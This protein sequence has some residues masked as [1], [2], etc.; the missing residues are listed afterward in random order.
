M[1]QRELY[2]LILKGE[3]TN[4]VTADGKR[5]STKIKLYGEDGEFNPAV[6][7]YCEEQIAKLDEKNAGRKDT[8]SEKEKR[9]ANADLANA[10]YSS[11]EVG[12]TYTATQLAEKFTTAENK[13]SA[14]KVTAVLKPYITDNKIVV[15]KGYK[16]E[17]A[18]SKVNGYALPTEG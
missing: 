12:K 18:K 10:I 1:T 7:D 15:I 11:F 3:G 9:A 13:V 4:T 6:I 14:Q 8:K 17:G 16:P 5:T 2:T